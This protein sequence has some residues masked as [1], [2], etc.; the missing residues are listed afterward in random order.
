MA[1]PATNVRRMRTPLAALLLLA[2]APLNA[3]TISGTQK[4][5]ELTLKAGQYALAADYTVPEG[6]RLIV[7]PG[8]VITGAKRATLVIRGELT[9]KGDAATPAIMRGQRWGGIRITDT[10]KAA[11]TGVQI[12]G[13]DPAVEVSGALDKVTDS[14]FARN[15]RGFVLKQ[16]GRVTFTNCLFVDNDET[17]INTGPEVIAKNCSFIKNKGFGIDAGES[18]PQCDSCHFADNGKGGLTQSN[19]GGSVG[20]SGVNCSFEGKGFGINIG[21]SHGSAVFTKCYWGDKSTALLRSK[22]DAVNLPNVNDARDGSGSIK[23][24]QDGFL[25][26]PPKGCGATVKSKV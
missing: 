7:E 3:L 14:V 20:L 6:K 26:A 15:A 18:S 21:S 4:E 23:V 13:A 2:A 11:L 25:S 5:A 24:R 10:G 1:A 17:A 8:A 22:G 9:V 16:T 19:A 12:A